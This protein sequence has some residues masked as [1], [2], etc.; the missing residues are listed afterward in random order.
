VTFGDYVLATVAETDNSMR[1]RLKPCI[2]FYGKL[3]LAGSV[4]TLNMKTYKVITRDR[5][6]IQTMSDLDI[7]KITELATRQC[8]A[9]GE[10]A[11][12]KIPDVLDDPCSYD[13][14]V[15][16]RRVVTEFR[17]RSRCMHV[18]DLYATSKSDNNFEKFENCTCG[19]YCEVKFNKE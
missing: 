5:I 18:A 1:P 15:F 19:V 9:R 4:Y 10:E 7:T 3:D 13:T 8:S 17:S 12:L 14:C 11:M 6:A 16:I 2:A